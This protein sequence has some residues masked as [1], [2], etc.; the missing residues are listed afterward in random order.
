MVRSNMRLEGFEA[1]KPSGWKPWLIASV[2]AV[3]ILVIAVGLMAMFGLFRPANDS[4]GKSLAA[5]LGLVGAVLSSVLALVGTIIKYSIDDRNAR[6]AAM[7]ASRNYALAIQAEQRN[8]IDAAIRAVD[9]LSENNDDST[10]TQM[11][12]AL[13]ALVSL[14]ELDLAVSLLA[15]LWPKGKTS[16]QV[17]EV[18]L[19][20]A[21]K[22]G[23]ED[24]MISAAS[25]VAQN[26]SRLSIGNFHIWPFTNPDWRKDLPYNARLNLIVA[27]AEW[28]LVAVEAEPKTLPTAALILFEALEDDEK[29]IG[30]LSAACLRPITLNLDATIGKTASSGLII[31][32][33]DIVERLKTKQNSS[34]RLSI[35]AERYESL[36]NEL[37]AKAPKTLSAL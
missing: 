18:I 6:Q 23:S 29:V 1:E 4:E 11:G 5:A 12:G 22:N 16:P 34:G 9:L 25:V 2:A 20:N 8:R 31:C 13:L 19:T 15:E 26:V 33:S 30:D 36:L 35:E 24:V 10:K 7:E 28:L 32:V 3:T 37:Y 21:F 17:A 27:V 14:G